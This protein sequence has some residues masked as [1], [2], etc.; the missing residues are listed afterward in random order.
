MVAPLPPGPFAC[1]LADPPWS[2]R[3]RS[4]KGEGRS[5]RRHYDTMELEA[6]KAMPI[7]EVAARDAHLFLWATAPNLPQA[8]EVM[9]AWGFR[10]SAVGFVWV[11]LNRSV[12]PHQL[13]LTRFIDAE[14][15]VGMGHTTRQNAEFVLLG[16]RGSP[17]R[18]S[19]AVRQ[20]IVAPRREHSRKPDELHARIETYCAGP[21]L[22]LF[23][24][25]QR[26]GWVTWGDQVGKFAAARA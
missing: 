8:F 26:P 22:E 6:I 11:K 13:R 4:A 23:A 2:Y 12:D 25:A 24:R 19:R 15:F 18:L 5:A 7:G 21:Y 1:I 3:T 16:R 20:I 9:A 10:Y 14:C 17:K